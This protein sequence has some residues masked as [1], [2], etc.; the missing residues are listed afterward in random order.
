MEAI[1]SFAG[2]LLC[3]VDQRKKRRK[4]GREIEGAERLKGGVK[5]KDDCVC[6]N[7]PLFWW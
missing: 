1:D 3:L 4:A 2:V 7:C 6:K 5:R